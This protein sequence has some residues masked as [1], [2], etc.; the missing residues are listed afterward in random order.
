MRRVTS[1]DIA[2]M[3]G[4][5]RSTVSRVINNYPNVPAETR[6]RVMRIIQEQHYY[7][8]LSGKLLAGEDQR[9]LGVFWV[10][11]GTLASDSLTSSYFMYM[12]DAASNL[13]YL[14]LAKVLPNLQEEALCQF[15]RRTFA[16]G[17]ISAGIFVGVDEGNPLVEELIAQGEHVGVF[18][19]P[20]HLSAPHCMT[21]N[22]DD[23]DG[24]RA[25]D[26]LYRLGHRDIGMLTGRMNRRSCQQRW[27]GFRRAMQ[28]H[29]LPLREDWIVPADITRDGGY[30]G[31]RR[32]WAQCGGKL[33]TALFAANDAAAFGVY[34]ACAELGVRVPEDLSV[35]GV[36]GHR[37]GASASPPL[38]TLSY[39]TH[40]MIT[41]LVERTIRADDA[42]APIPRDEV[43]RSSLMERAS[44]V[45][46]RAD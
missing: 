22:F 43:F 21:V 12:L 17:R 13:G 4:V 15:V 44:C 9:T 26:Y 29:Q 39:D 35:L 14:V 16:E 20:A 2:R 38:T 11:S 10:G 45:P 28:A 40:A 8:Q 27:E 23:L 19:Y 6:E 24:D 41:S 31:M 32:L 37:D 42:S 18:D 46:V 33:P 3:A 36:D 25:V 7:P 1:S 34:Q 5:S 30:R